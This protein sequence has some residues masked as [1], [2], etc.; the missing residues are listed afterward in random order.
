[1]TAQC[2]ENERLVPGYA[3][4]ST[5]KYPTEPDTEIV[6]DE[7]IANAVCQGRHPHPDGSTGWLRFKIRGKCRYYFQNRPE[8]VGR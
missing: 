1:M 4:T 6:G 2:L 5:R 8:L 7:E 3:E